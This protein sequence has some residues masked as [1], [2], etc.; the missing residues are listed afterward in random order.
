[1]YNKPEGS[2]LSMRNYLK[3]V[4]NNLKVFIALFAN[5]LRGKD[6]HHWWIVYATWILV[7]ITLVFSWIQYCSYRSFS[8][9]ENR[10]YLSIIEP[11]MD[12]KHKR[13]TFIIKNFGKT[14]V[15]NVTMGVCFQLRD[16][17]N[18]NPEI[19]PRNKEKI[20]FYLPPEMPSPHYVC[21]DTLCNGR[22]IY[23]YGMIHYIDKYE[24]W[25]F[26]SFGFEYEITAGRFQFYPDLNNAN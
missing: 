19:F 18:Y 15:Y 9:I 11:A 13:A 7:L 14:P 23:L 26:T 20:G 1:M 4:I 24:E 3:L 5:K 2:F 21:L 17:L 12:I 6:A 8:Q 22:R 10:A 16:S 25:H